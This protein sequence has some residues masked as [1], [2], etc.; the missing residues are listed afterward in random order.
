MLV[1]RQRATLNGRIT[2]VSL[3]LWPALSYKVEL[4][5][6][7]GTVF[8]RLTGRSALPG[9]DPGRWLSVEGTPAEVF[10]QLVIL[11]PL[12]SFVPDEPGATKRG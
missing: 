9:F 1:P 12:Y 10:G 4:N 3:H 6:G 11:N 7:T 2:T 5:D 8:L